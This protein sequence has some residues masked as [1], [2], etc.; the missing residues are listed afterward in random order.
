MS[1][2]SERR[3]RANERQP[4]RVGREERKGGR[5]ATS[6]TERWRKEEGNRDR[7]REQ[8]E[9]KRGRAQRESDAKVCC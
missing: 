6:E 9:G 5:E 4:V 8:E 3:E 7:Q 2:C 1:L